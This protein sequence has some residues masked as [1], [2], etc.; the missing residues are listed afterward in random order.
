[1]DKKDVLNVS[2]VW[3]Y[4][5]GFADY[6]IKATAISSENKTGKFDILPGHAN[7]I[8]VIYN[9]LVLYTPE[10]KKRIY[11]FEKGIVQVSENNVKLFLEGKI[12]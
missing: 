3:H 12:D 2:V 1:M 11:A 5:S 8:C 4:F 10:K 7:F 6:E 9:N